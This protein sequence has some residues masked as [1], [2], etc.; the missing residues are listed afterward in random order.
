MIEVSRKELGDLIEELIEVEKQEDG[1][2][3]E[4]FRLRFNNKDIDE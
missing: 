4:K 1:S 3:F 2:G